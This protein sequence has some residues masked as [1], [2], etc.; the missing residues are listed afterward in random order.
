M[1]DTNK[2]FLDFTWQSTR[3]TMSFLAF[4]SWGWLCCLWLRRWSNSWA[5]WGRQPW[6]RREARCSSCGWGQTPWSGIRLRGTS[7]G[8]WRAGWTF[9]WSGWHP[10]RCAPTRQCTFLVLTWRHFS[11]RCSAH[12]LAE[13]PHPQLWVMQAL[14]IYAH[15]F[16]CKWKF[17]TYLQE[18]KDVW[19]TGGLK[20]WSFDRLDSFRDSL[21][22]DGVVSAW[23]QIRH[24]E[25]GLR[26]EH[27][28]TVAIER[29]QLVVCNLQ[30]NAKYT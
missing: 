8:A 13:E 15:Y 5:G 22:R 24:R 1:Q 4:A 14:Q 17:A 19:L 12:R 6:R 16:F 20:D 23:Q 26:N 18:I 27:A 28:A 21:H 25:V 10:C 29:L 3:W 2:D 9:R 7:P 30:R 11:T